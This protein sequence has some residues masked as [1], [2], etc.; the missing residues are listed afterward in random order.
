MATPEMASMPENNRG[1][2][3]TRPLFT[4]N[5]DGEVITGSNEDELL[6]KIKQRLRDRR[7][8]VH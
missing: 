7:E 5:L 4:T 6:K 3:E 8:T 1:S 2:M